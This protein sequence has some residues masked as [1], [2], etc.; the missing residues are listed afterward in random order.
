M[1]PADSKAVRSPR[2]TISAVEVAA[3]TSKV[4]TNSAATQVE[5]V[6]TIDALIVSLL[7]SEALRPMAFF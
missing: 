4:V 7:K 1:N 5:K 2:H 3:V 6:R